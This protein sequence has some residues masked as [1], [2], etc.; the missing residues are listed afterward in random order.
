M[1]KEKKYEMQDAQPNIVEEPFVMYGT[2]DLEDVRVL[3]I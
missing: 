3:R 1:E 2:L